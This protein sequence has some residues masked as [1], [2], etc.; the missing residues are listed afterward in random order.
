MLCWWIG[1]GERA[2]K[3][4]GHR[5]DPKHLSTPQPLLDEV[6]TA[7]PVLHIFSIRWRRLSAHGLDALVPD[8]VGEYLQ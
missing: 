3:R 6:D 7:Y 5:R 4:Q 8:L 2:A 1:E